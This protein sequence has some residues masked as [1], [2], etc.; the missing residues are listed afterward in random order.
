MYT[1]R[2]RRVQNK[3]YV[4]LCAMYAGRDLLA[5]VTKGGETRPCRGALALQGLAAMFGS[6]LGTVGACVVDVCAGGDV[7]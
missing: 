3:K 7:A 1:Q 5:H 4:Y 6:V 2:E